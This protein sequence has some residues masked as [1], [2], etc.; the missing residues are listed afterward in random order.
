MSPPRLLR[1]PGPVNPRRIDSFGG[2]PVM[3]Q[4]PLHKGRTLTEALAAPLVEAGLQCATVRFAGA[5]LAPFRYVIPAPASDDR[6]VAYF[7]APH[8]PAGASRV[9]LASATFG[10]S[11]GQPAIHCHAVWRE[12]DGT[13]RGGHILPNETIVVGSAAATA[14][15]F[16]QIRIAT[17]ADPETNF[18]LFKPSGENTPGT[19]IVARVAP[20]EDILTAIEGIAR[21]HGLRD[22]AIRGSLGSLVGARFTDG[23]HVTD[24]ATE[25]LVRDG[26]VR[27]GVAALELLV[28][29]MRGAV[30]QGWLERGQNPVCITFDLVLEELRASA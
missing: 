21:T 1:Q 29:D 6:H 23:A 27:D 12:P 7:S 20:N 11:D 10:W 8:A 5:D 9:E 16:R 24:H 15:G 19:G 18:T 22:A 2:E 26:H 4:F 13:R 3:L 28:A 30:H 14:W 17:Q 25:V